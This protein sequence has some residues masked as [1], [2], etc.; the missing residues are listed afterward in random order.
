MS[1]KETK[2]KENKKTKKKENKKTEYQHLV[3]Y[4]KEKKMTYDKKGLLKGKAVRKYKKKRKKD[5]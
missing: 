5:R 1:I 3:I 4:I 2:K